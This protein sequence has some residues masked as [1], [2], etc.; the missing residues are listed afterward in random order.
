M[1]AWVGMHIIDVLVLVLV[2]AVPGEA[3]M[4]DSRLLPHVLPRRLGPTAV[5]WQVV[6]WL[7]SWAPPIPC[8]SS[9]H[10]KRSRL[11]GA[12]AAMAR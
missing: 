11:E 9:W 6:K 4:Q 10:P 12:R 1:A 2:V 3:R 7:A 5:A 8:L